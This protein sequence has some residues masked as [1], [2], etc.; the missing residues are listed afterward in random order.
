MATDLM[1]LLGSSMEDTSKKRELEDYA[2]NLQTMQATRL[3]GDSALAIADASTGQTK[4]ARDTAISKLK[5]GIEKGTGTGDFKVPALMK[6]VLADVKKSG[7]SPAKDRKEWMGAMIDRMGQHPELTAQTL[8]FSNA[9]ASITAKETELAIKQQELGLKLQDSKIKVAAEERQQLN[10]RIERAQKLLEIEREPDERAKLQ[11]E[12][13]NTKS[14][15][16]E[17]NAMLSANIDAKVASAEASRARAQASQASARLSDAKATGKVSS[18]AASSEFKTANELREAVAGGDWYTATIIATKVAE[19]TVGNADEMTQ[20]HA[21]A[22]QAGNTVQA[23]NVAQ[24]VIANPSGGIKEIREKAAAFLSTADNEE[25]GLI[26]QI[27]GGVSAKIDPGDHQ[28]IQDTTLRL[29]AVDVARYLAA[30]NRADRQGSVSKANLDDAKRMLGIDQFWGASREDIIHAIDNATQWIQRDQ[31]KH[32]ENA[33]RPKSEAI[34]KA[35]QYVGKNIEFM[36]S[37]K[38]M[39]LQ[40]YEVFPDGKRK[41]PQ[42]VVR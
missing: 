34:F 11:A 17:R 27:I 9:L 13:D 29:A 15:I 26:S 37:A 12:I 39:G 38:D 21:K 32:V 16:S 5:M 31:R 30:F 3:R 35:A 41:I 40:I 33:A 28:R 36:Y 8:G 24:G 42:A 14:Q 4:L 10:D 7:A 23:L 18:A 19:N 6:Q 1:E 22:R 2:R 20:A 25:R